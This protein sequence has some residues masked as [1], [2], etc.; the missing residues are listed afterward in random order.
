MF[1]V[2]PIRIYPN[3]RICQI[4]YHKIDGDITEYD[5]DKYQNNHD[6]QPSLMFKELNPNAAIVDPQLKLDFGFERA[7]S[8]QETDP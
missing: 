4:F 3:V 6:I 1:A 5:S 7:R 8:I 2:Q